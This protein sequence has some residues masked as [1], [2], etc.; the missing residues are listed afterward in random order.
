MSEGTQAAPAVAPV[1]K[2]A[3]YAA[4]AKAQGLC[5]AA[6]LD[7]KYEHGKVKY[8]FTSANERLAVARDALSKCDLGLLRVE[9]KVTQLTIQR[10]V[11]DKATGE[12]TAEPSATW[13]LEQEWALVHASGDHLVLGVKWPVPEVEHFRPL[14]K[15]VAAADTAALSYL[16]RDVLLIPSEES[17]TEAERGPHTNVVKMP[18]RPPQPGVAPARPSLAGSAPTSSA[19]PTTSASPPAPVQPAS[20]P[21]E[22]KGE[23]RAVE[24]PA[25]ESAPAPVA[26][27][28][29]V[30]TPKAEAPK[31][32]GT[33]LLPD[34]TAG[35]VFDEA[36]E[37]NGLGQ[38]L[39]AE[40]RA[41]AKL[42]SAPFAA[43]RLYALQPDAQNKDL[44]REVFAVAE[45]RFGSREAAIAK[46]KELG[47][48]QGAVPTV[49]L[50][51]S[52]VE[53]MP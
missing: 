42:Q 3:L 32:D 51:R 23:A 43:Q 8:P 34:E 37:K 26:G 12:T 1:K 45:K 33:A 28:P 7:G 30:E 22:S 10:E 38:Q 49:A 11:V 50:L 19:A 17:D 35:D 47:N 9:S 31:T 21:S 53:V 46:F 44:Y 27:A 4:L 18:S 20:P 6:E 40:E 13:L 41:K 29:P 24:P 2:A 36:V 39:A 52:L 16:L 5:R 15:A 48:P 25:T 14:E